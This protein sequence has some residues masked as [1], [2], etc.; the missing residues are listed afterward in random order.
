VWNFNGEGERMLS[1]FFL[2]EECS[3]T[4]TFIILENY[5]SSRDVDI[6]RWVLR[7]HIDSTTKLQYIIPDGTRLQSGKVLQIYA[8][9]AGGGEVKAF[10]RNVV[11]SL[12]SQE[13]VNN[14][15]SSW[16]MSAGE[17]VK[18]FC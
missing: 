5:S 6:S 10:V 13:L 14:D 7:R 18:L 9:R 4:G 2:V 11:S 15:I 8:K 17:C 1:I 3:P 12:K 16:G